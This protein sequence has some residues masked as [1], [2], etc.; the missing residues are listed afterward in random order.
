M[1]KLLICVSIGLV[2]LGAISCERDCCTEQQEN[3]LVGKW[4]LYE[5][6]WSPGAGYFID[7]VSPV[8]PQ[9]MEFK[10]NGEL[11]CSVEGITDYNFYSVR[12]DIVGL[13]KDDPGPSPDSLAFTYSY[14]FR[15]NDGNL[16]L[17]FRYCDEGCHLAFK[18]VER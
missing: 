2:A 18:Q 13:F 1:K 12:G 4:L 5:R 6:G 7:P 16:E 11:S 14:L 9:E 8:P 3:D 15:F 17:W 10:N